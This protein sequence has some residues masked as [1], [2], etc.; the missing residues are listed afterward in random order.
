M[1]ICDV[2]CPLKEPDLPATTTTSCWHTTACSVAVVSLETG[3]CG[4]F[5]LPCFS[6]TVVAP[7]SYSL[8]KHQT[9]HGK[10][11]TVAF[12]MWKSISSA[13]NI[14]LCSS[15]TTSLFWITV[16][17]YSQWRNSDAQ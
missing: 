1:T 11:G 13:T 3:V 6:A 5:C 17:Q 12:V 9:T 16:V 2:K 4:W 8:S 7:C 14:P 10:S 15:L